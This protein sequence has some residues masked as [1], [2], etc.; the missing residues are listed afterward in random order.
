M[1]KIARRH[2]RS[3]RVLIPP[4]E[5]QHC[6]VKIIKDTEKIINNAVKGVRAEL[7]LLHEYRTRLIADV[8]TGKLDV[9]E[10]ATRLP[11][12]EAEPKQ[13]DEAQALI[14]AADAER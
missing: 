13:F 11:D 3:W 12:G 6:I 9:R 2:I 14:D 4:L 1:P 5:E 8:V 7:S 10:A